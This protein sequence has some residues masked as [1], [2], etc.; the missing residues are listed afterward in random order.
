MNLENDL[1]V[2]LNLSYKYDVWSENLEKDIISAQFALKSG[3]R[4]G[5]KE[6][7]KPLL[8]VCS[9]IRKGWEVLVVVQLYGKANGTTDNSW[10]EHM[11]IASNLIQRKIGK[12]PRRVH[13]N[14][15]FKIW[16]PVRSV[17]LLG[18][19][20]YCF[21]STNSIFFGP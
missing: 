17:V 6:K 20:S 16:F 4:H 21:F 18:L 2:K 1:R 13:F 15:F 5:K 19:F 8:L 14:K 9:E 7:Q 11:Y 3:E 10:K 12:T